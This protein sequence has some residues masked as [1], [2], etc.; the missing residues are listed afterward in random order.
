MNVPLNDDDYYR[1]ETEYDYE[2]E[3]MSTYMFQ[4]CAWSTV[5]QLVH[6]IY[7]ILAVSFILLIFSFN[8]VPVKHLNVLNSLLSVSAL[9]Y[10]YN[11]LLIAYLLVFI[12][13]IYLVLY[14]ANF[15]QQKNAF[16][17]IACSTVHMFMGRMFLFSVAD[18]NS[19][20]GIEMILIMK[21]ISLVIDMKQ[22]TPLN[23][24]DLI[25][26]LLSVNTALFGPW[27]SYANHLAAFGHRVKR[28]AFVNTLNSVKS[29]C[30][31]IVCL[32]GSSCL[33]NLVDPYLNINPFIR[34]YFEAF[35]FRLSNY[36]VAFLSQ[37]IVNLSGNHHLKVTRPLFIEM[38]RSLLDVVTNWNIPIHDWLKSYVFKPIKSWKPKQTLFA[39]FTT[40]FV[41]SMLHA[42]DESISLIL[43]SLGFYTYVEFNLRKNLSKLIGCCVQARKC[44]NGCGHKFKSNHLISYIL[45]ICFS[46]VNVYHLAYLG[47]VLFHVNSS[48]TSNG[49]EI[50]INK[51]SATYYSSHLISLIYLIIFKL[52]QFLC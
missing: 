1:I 36:F 22:K 46:L 41:S 42:F 3:D 14:L 23:L 25:S 28:N 4:Q 20:K 49:Y 27:V 21:I 32:I 13:K 39:V 17:I 37:A 9:F 8:N 29:F 47:Q 33:L 24:T 52:T 34:I 50:A 18:W 10:L 45:N 11:P 38:P 30:I 2:Y 43:F 51:W 5:I 31:S 44:S 19:V 12:V 16:I 35:S 15:S 48:E 6:T 26:Y 7:P 40:Y